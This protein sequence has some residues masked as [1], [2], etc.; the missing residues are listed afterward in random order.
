MILLVT[1]LPRCPQHLCFPD[2]PSQGHW[3][4]QQNG[5]NIIDLGQRT[6]RLDPRLVFLYTAEFT[7]T[8]PQPVLFP[9]YNRS[10]PYYNRTIPPTTGLS[11]N[12]SMRLLPR[13]TL[14]PSIPMQPSALAPDGRCRLMKYHL[15][16]EIRT[17]CDG[18]YTSFVFII[19]TSS[20]IHIIH[21]W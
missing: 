4:D 10:I 14:W 7:V 15:Y 19:Y 6:M 21:M 8:I 1:S 2:P 9:Y 3:I 20:Y 16:I 5:F 13:R 18:S 11:L 12:R 17:Y